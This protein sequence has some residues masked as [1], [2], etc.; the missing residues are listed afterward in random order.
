MPSSRYAQSVLQKLL[1]LFGIALMGV[2][3]IG[4]RTVDASIPRT[5]ALD[6]TR[7]A[8]A[9]KTEGLD[10][11]VITVSWSG[12]GPTGQDGSNQTVVLQCSANPQTVADCFTADPYPAIANG[13]RKL[14]RTLDDGTGSVQFEV[15]PAAQLPV[16]N[17]SESNP[18]SVLVY[19]SG[20]SSIPADGLPQTA[21]VVALEFAPSVADCPPVTDF[22]LRFDGSASASTLFYRWAAEKCDGRNAIVIDYTTGGDNT[23]RENFL[24]GLVDG[25]VTGLAASKYELESHSE[26]EDFE[27]APVDLTAVAVVVNMRDPMTGEPITDLTLSPRLVARLITDSDV[28]NLFTDPEF[29][30]LNA[31][32]RLPLNGLEYP[33]LRAEKNSDSYIVTSWLVSDEDTSLFLADEDVYNKPVNDAYIGLEYPRDIF[34]NVAQSANFLPRQ[35]QINVAL[36][37]FY[38]ISPSGTTPLNPTEIG[39]LGIVDFPTAQ[40]FGLPT[41]KLV[42]AAGVAVAPTEESILAGFESMSTLRNGT[43]VNDFSSTNEDAYPL[44]KVDYMMVPTKGIDNEKNESLQAFLKFV[45]GA[46]QDIL[47]PGYVELPDDLKSQTLEVIESLQDNLIPESTTSTTTSTTTTT[48]Y[49]PDT[50]S[51]DSYDTTTTTSTPVT[52]TTT[53][54]PTVIVGRPALETLP[55]GQSLQTVPFI[56]LGGIMSSIGAFWGRIRKGPKK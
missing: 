38:G 56:F 47:L 21:A 24:A 41:A 31:R 34:E 18:C 23:G 5:A 14:G 46:G 10:N 20:E 39:L 11:E 32:V 30:R 37:M 51:Y 16:L 13:N 42:N 49:T 43:K 4:I 22:D 15:R 28:T 26:I 55:R 7:S 40:R 33:V 50:T 36:K 19:E 17:C 12:F 45:V 8:S 48:V 3:F 2:G 29:R 6:P 9:S 52:T 53:S 44:V 54:T 25:G 27:Y 1:I 35:G